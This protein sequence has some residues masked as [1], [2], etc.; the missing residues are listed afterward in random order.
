[1]TVQAMTPAPLSVRTRRRDER[2]RL[3]RHDVLSARLA[4]LTRIEGLLVAAQAIVGED[5]VQHAWFR[6][7]DTEGRTRLATAH[8]LGRMTGRPVVGACLVGAEVQAG[9]GVGAATSQL[10]ARSLDLTWHTLRDACGVVEWCPSPPVR[11]ARVRD[12]T[13]WNDAPGRDAGQVAALL[14][15]TT[16]A[17][18]AEACR[19]R[20]ERFAL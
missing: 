14:A 10:V 18:R 2:R 12:L 8:D 19:V 15:A 7:Q 3:A 6:Y 16:H 17:A 4:E 1:V 13:R 9:G 20:E 11:Q 5:W